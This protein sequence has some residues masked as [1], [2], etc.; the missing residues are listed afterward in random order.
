[1][2]KTGI[3]VKSGYL[4]Q[5]RFLVVAFWAF[6]NSRIISVVVDFCLVE[7]LSSLSG[8]GPLFRSSSIPKVHCADMHYS[9]NILVKVRVKARVKVR[10]RVKV[11]FSLRVR[12]KVSGNSGP[13]SLIHAVGPLQSSYKLVYGSAVS[14]PSWPWVQK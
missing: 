1:M 2:S 8:T 11:R 13:E 10:I 6:G 12:P 3:P 9:S 5:L 14:S 7:C 4:S